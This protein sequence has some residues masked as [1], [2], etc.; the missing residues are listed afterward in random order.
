M[1]VKALAPQSLRAVCTAGELGCKSSDELLP[2][3]G[4]I[5]QENAVKALR[6]G[7]EIRADGFNVFVAGA[8]GTG[9]T[10]AVKG[11]LEEVAR[12]KDVPPDLCYINNFADPYRPRVLS[13]PPGRGTELAR[14]MKQF[15]T[16]ARREI[17]KAFESDD[18]TQRRKDT[19]EIFTSQRKD[20]IDG[21]NKRALE[22]GMLIQ[23]T[24]VGIFL[25]PVR[26]G[27]PL[28]DQE[29]AALSPEEKRAIENK[30]ELLQRELQATLREV[31]N[32]EKEAGKALEKLDREVAI[33]VLGHLFSDLLQKYAELPAV[34]A[35][36]EEVKA[37]VLENIAQ[38]RSEG[39]G[40][41]EV[42]EHRTLGLGSPSWIKD[43]P[44]RKYEV[45]VIVDNSQLVGAPVVIELNPT[46]NNLFGRIEKEAQLGALV[47]DFT[48]IRE[49]SLH[50]ANGGYLVLPV[51]EL[52]KVMFSWDALKRALKN[53]EISLE[54]PGERLGYITAKSLSP[55]AIPLNVKVILIG[56]SLLYRLLYFYDGDFRELFKVKAE[57]DTTMAR[58]KENIHRY[59][60]FICTLCQ[61]E[62]LLH[63][64][65]GA[66]AQVIEHSSRLAEHQGKLTTR[67]AEI[68][69]LVR[70]ANHYAA[71]DGSAYMGAVHIRAA[72]K[73][74]KA[75]STLPA[76]RLRELIRE[77]QIL[78]AT[79]DKVVGQVNGLAVLDL[80]DISFGR[81]T[82]I[83]ASVGPGREGIIDIEREVKLGGPIHS[84]GVMILN[85]FLTARYGYDHPLGLT[86]RLVFEQSYQGVEGDSASSTELYALLS[87]LSGLPLKQGIAVTGSVNQ[88][89]EVQAIGGVNEKIEGFFAVCSEE[90]LNGEQ[91]VII[92]AGNTPHL[93][94]KDE[95]VEAVARGKFNI[96]A[97]KTI[98]E[99]ISILTDTP[100]GTPNAEGKYPTGTVNYLV[101]KRLSELAQRAREFGLE[102]GGKG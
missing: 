62:K 88:K 18:Y 57:F 78:I 36:L 6:F 21:I 31:K 28:R 58:N 23:S 94:L 48:M 76:K 59:S 65:A 89:G 97:V 12:E 10:T 44:F 54:E 38:F 34:T 5:G 60:S 19:L 52:S 42:P 4:I 24:Q 55:E 7:L 14:D 98:D 64:D 84:K 49:G 66:L 3:E 26:D 16:T 75:R 93:M 20:L 79:S 100:A 33:F 71:A 22:E 85:G 30:R 45:N 63:L 9:R 61:K 13:L 95:V 69:D 53:G 17:P 43:L 50:R 83:T 77:G 70:E 87:S 32:L 1:P 41:G 72:I 90:G 11:F 67:F 102:A 92:P 27:Q 91:G 86:A 74:R 25:I 68:A 8:A 99:G 15:L 73:E 47:T 40:K 81:P 46:H 51:E 39:G 35:Y 80:G 2:L 56:D 37:D 29:L 101:Q 82:R 96:W